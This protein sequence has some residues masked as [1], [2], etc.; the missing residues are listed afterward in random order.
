MQIKTF[1]QTPEPKNFLQNTF[2]ASLQKL[3]PMPAY[4][5]AQASM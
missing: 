5:Q 2:S 4:H 1:K 3:F